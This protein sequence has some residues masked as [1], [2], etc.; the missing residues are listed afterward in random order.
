ML[1]VSDDDGE[2]KDPSPNKKSSR[3]N[4]RVRNYT[5][6]LDNPTPDDLRHVALVLVNWAKALEPDSED[7]TPQ[8]R[9]KT[10]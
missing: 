2:M 4:D 8:K 9:R 3:G 10:K 5:F 1:E 7:E 6:D